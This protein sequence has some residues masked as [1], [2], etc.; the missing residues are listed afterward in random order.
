MSNRCCWL[1]GKETRWRPPV[2]CGA[3]R[4]SKGGGTEKAEHGE[5]LQSFT[6]RIIAF[7]SAAKRPRGEKSV[8]DFEK[9]AS[10]ATLRPTPSVGHFLICWNGAFNFHCHGTFRVI[11]ANFDDGN[12]IYWSM[13]MCTH[14]PIGSCTAFGTNKI[15]FAGRKSITADKSLLKWMNS[16]FSLRCS[17]E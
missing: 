12:L 15:N 13:S 7:V 8:I 4:W 1:E 14:R 6:G 5:D 11:G 16:L 10:A 9:L 3:T 17:F 2:I